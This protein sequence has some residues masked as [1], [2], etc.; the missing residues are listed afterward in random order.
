M[1]VNPFHL[2]IPVHSMQAARD[3]YGGIL[4]LVEGRRSGDKWQDYS[5]FGHQ[6]VCHYVGETYRCQDFYNPVVQCKIKL[7]KNSVS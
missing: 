1:N 4:N 5:L 3:F 6:L 2:A 7:L